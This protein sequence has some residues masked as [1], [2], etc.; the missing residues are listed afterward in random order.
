M[1]G[2]LVALVVVGQAGGAAPS[3][4]TAVGAKP[5]AASILG[6]VFAR[7]AT[8]ER[9]TGKIL[10]S[11]T[12]GGGTAGMET[13]LQYE[14]PSRLYLRQQK[15]GDPID[16]LITSDGKHF[17]YNAPVRQLPYVDPKERMVE[18]VQTP[19]ALHTV[20]LIYAAG[21]DAI[22]DRS[23]P[24]DIAIGRTEDLQFVRATWANLLYVGLQSV[25][26]K[27]CHVIRGDHRVNGSSPVSG[28][29][30]IAVTAEYDL[31]RYQI[32]QRFAPP[33]NPEAMVDVLF[34]WDVSLEVNGTVD[35]KL[36][37][38]RT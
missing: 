15:P 17:S 33:T 11:A 3:S 9:V 31:V 26:G 20:P 24:L 25:N 18:P 36:F 8:A 16:F 30:E 29:F 10:H 27:E 38:V 1:I 13:E 19:F 37:R 32:I 7:Y 12:G 6:R 14:R 4:P 35:P 5:S 21:S 34:N 28:R 22:K 23:V 2:V